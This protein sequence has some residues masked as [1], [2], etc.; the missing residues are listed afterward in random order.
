[1]ERTKVTVRKKKIPEW[2]SN[3]IVRCI[4]TRI[5][6]DTFNIATQ[7]KTT[8]TLDISVHLRVKLTIQVRVPEFQVLG[9][10]ILLSVN[11]SVF[12]YQ[13][14]SIM[15]ELI[16]NIH[17]LGLSTFLS[18]KNPTL[19]TGMTLNYT[20]KKKTSSFSCATSPLN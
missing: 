10:E 20:K 3:A 19:F 2:K 5:S 1:M 16:V 12:F 17:W 8:T 9:R 4:T 13:M 15:C 18:C 14:A 11:F 7:P 6:L